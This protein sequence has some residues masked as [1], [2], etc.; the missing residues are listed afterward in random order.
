MASKKAANEK[1]RCLKGWLAF[2]DIYGF[3]DE[4]EKVKIQSL[5]ARLDKLHAKLL[6]LANNK[7]LIFYMF[8]DSVVLF[9][10]DAKFNETEGLSTLID[11]LRTSQLR[12]LDEDFMLRG[13]ICHGEMALSPNGFTGQP[14]LKAARLEPQLALPLI[15]IL[16]VDLNP[17]ADAFPAN[18]TLGIIPT[19]SGIVRGHVILP[20]PVK[21]MLEHAT[22]RLNKHLREG[23]D[24]VARTWKGLVDFLEATPKP[25]DKTTKK[26]KPR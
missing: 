17:K 15:V 1:S 16:D 7:G 18:R 23:P 12:A 14:L 5:A 9:A 13:A 21:P 8:S 10:E 19:K 2:F 11:A 3:G 26:N 20:S 22:K 25:G 24:H 4:I 6:D